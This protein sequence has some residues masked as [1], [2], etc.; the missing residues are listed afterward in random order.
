[1]RVLGGLTG[2]DHAAAAASRPPD[3]RPSTDAGGCPALGGAGGWF[4]APSPRGSSPASSRSSS[5][6]SCSAGVATYVALGSFLTDGS[7]SSCTLGRQRRACA[8]CVAACSSA[9]PTAV[10]AAGTGRH[11]SAV[12]AAR[13]AARL[14]LSMLDP[15]G[16]PV[17]LDDRTAPTC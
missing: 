13:L 9:I 16:T 1:M 11:S 2:P 5:S 6:S 14:W 10:P 7:T 12:N 17:Q 8:A 3:S 15:N 4:P